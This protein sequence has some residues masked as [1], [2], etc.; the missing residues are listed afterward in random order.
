MK[1]LY[2]IRHAKSDWNS[3][4]LTD[5]ERT[6]NKQGFNE[7][8]FMAKKLIEY[9]FKPDHIICSPAKRTTSTAQLICAEINYPLKDIIFEHSIYEASVNAL[10]SLVNSL[11]N[12][13]NEITIIGHNP[14]ITEL[15]NYLT[16]EHIG[17]MPTCS[18]IKIELE[19]DNWD[20]ITRGIGIQKFFIYPKAFIQ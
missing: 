18:I 2:L 19:I 17:N 7:A 16:D 12:N 1:T 6:L 9:N 3:S 11:P 5:F 13:K 8:P 4:D 20:E 14:S 15:S 10:V